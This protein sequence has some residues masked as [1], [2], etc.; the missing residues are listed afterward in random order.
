MRKKNVTTAHFL[1][2]FNNHASNVYS[3]DISNL[4]FSD[5]GTSPQV[6]STSPST[7]SPSPPDTA[8][9]IRPKTK[10]Y[11]KTHFI[12][13]VGI[14]WRNSYAMGDLDTW[15]MELNQVPDDNGVHDGTE[16]F[17]YG[18]FSL[19]FPLSKKKERPL[20]LGPSL[21]FDFPHGN[22][23][24]WPIQGRVVTY[25]STSPVNYIRLKPMM[26]GLSASLKIPFSEISAFT[27]APAIMYGSLK[28]YSYGANDYDTRNYTGSGM[29]F[30][31][32]AGAEVF[33]GRD[34]R[35][36][37]WAA[38]GYRSLKTGLNYTDISGLSGP[39]LMQSGKEVKVDLSGVSIF[40]GLAMR[41]K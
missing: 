8:N 10:V 29:G 5:I 20:C 38:L 18:G 32:T 21:V 41:L 7:T 39:V 3:A 4:D 22:P 33:M 6:T 15:F 30:S 27:V 13:D 14:A 34:R 1:I 23:L 35:G 26:I 12:V 9:N 17:W 31:V 28:G 11:T 37:F 25:A 16:S 40:L 19:Y 24:A 36:I 2:R